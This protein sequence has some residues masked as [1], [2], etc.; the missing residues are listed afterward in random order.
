MNAEQLKEDIRTEQ[1]KHTE[2][3]VT[4]AELNKKLKEL[5]ERHSSANKRIRELEQQTVSREKY[6]ELTQENAKLKRDLKLASDTVKEQVEI[7]TI[8][9]E[10]R[11]LRKYKKAVEDLINAIH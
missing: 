8:I 7:D 1:R 6:I 2:L 3:H 11:S 10:N 4:I 5:S 9:E